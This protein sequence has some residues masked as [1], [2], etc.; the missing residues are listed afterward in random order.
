MSD[1]VILN[2]SIFRMT[3]AKKKFLKS[4][5]TTISTIKL[6]KQL[7]RERR[8]DGIRNGINSRS[9][10]NYF[11]SYRAAA[12]RNLTI[13]PVT[14]LLVLKRERVWAIEGG[15]YCSMHSARRQDTHGARE[16]ER[17]R[18]HPTGI[19]RRPTSMY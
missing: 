6:I 11:Q 5:T 19:R 4:S 12:S 16:R 9:A 18:I 10:V 15:K 1:I 8:G 13:L 3:K 17:E 14:I 2:C 7:F